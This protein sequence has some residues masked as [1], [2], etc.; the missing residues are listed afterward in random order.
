MSEMTATAEMTMSDLLD[1]YPGAQRALFRKYHIG[2]CSSCGFRPDETLEGVCARNE[3]LDPDE[4]LMAVQAGHEADEAMMLDPV[5]VKALRDA[6]VEAVEILDI[7]TAEEYEAVH[8]AGSRRLDQASMQETLSLSPKD[9]LLVLLDH[10]GKR[11]LDAAAYLAGHGF[12]NVKC[13]RGGI[14][15]WSVVIDST[16][17]RYTLE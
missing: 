2:G 15:A 12:T 3:G 4:V 14:D 16:L 17:P 13:L 5:E 10:D 6:G 8:L 9:R 7:R 1:A 11:S